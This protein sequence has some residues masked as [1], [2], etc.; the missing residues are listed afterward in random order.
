[1]WDA[2][3]IAAGYARGYFLMHDEDSGCVQW[4]TT[5]RE[6]AIIP[7][8]D[9]FRYPRSLRRL[10][11]RQPFQ[12]RIDTAFAEVVGGCADRSETWISPE[13]V[14]IYMTLH[15]AGWAHSFEIWQ[16]ERLVGGL[17]G[18]VLGGAFIGES[19]YHV[20]PNASKV[21]LVALVQHLRSRGFSLLD[22]QISNP[23]LERFGA[24]AMPQAEYLHRLEVALR[25]NCSWHPPTSARISETM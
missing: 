4:F 11:K 19:M 7:L 8:D 16:A 20:V 10:L 14:E 5:P 12:T 3:A 6:R 1:M 21:G 9:R 24:I 13:L 23:H 25:Q 2:D 15:G 17:L 18:I 22:A